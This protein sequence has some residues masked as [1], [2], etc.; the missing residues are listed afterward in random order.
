MRN[1]QKTRGALPLLRLMKTVNPLGKQ[2]VA[3]D[4]SSPSWMVLWDRPDRRVIMVLAIVAA[5]VFIGFGTEVLPANSR[6][7]HLIF[8][9]P[10]LH[11]L[12]PFTIQNAEHVLLFIGLGELYVRWRSAAKEMSYLEMNLLPEDD[13]TVLEA[14]DLGPI[15]KRVAGLSDRQHGILPTLIEV[16]ILQFQSGRSIDQTVS[17]MNSNLELIQHRIDLSYSLIRYIAWLIP[18]LGFIG[19]T[20]GIGSALASVPEGGQIDMAQLAQELSVGFDC[21]MV[22]LAE[23]AVL[24]F[25]LHIVQE[26]EELGVNLAGTYTL[27]NFIN[28]L[29]SSPT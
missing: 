18:T 5:V 4:N 24:V 15:R 12:Y 8:D 29:F 27:R 28:R 3:P 9:H 20:I 21:T 17:V 7:A 23:S 1:D 22:A 14:A 13:E 10:S 19:T 26:Q 2:A 6:A 11:F 25:F 16:S